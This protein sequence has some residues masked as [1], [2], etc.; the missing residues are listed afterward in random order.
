[1]TQS[2]ATL[3]VIAN[4]RAAEHGVDR[5]GYV[6]PLRSATAGPLR[7]W[8]GS[9]AARGRRIGVGLPPH[10]R[11]RRRPRVVAPATAPNC[12]RSFSSASGSTLRPQRRGSAGNAGAGAR[13]RGPGN[14]GSV[15][16]EHLQRPPIRHP[17]PPGLEIGICYGD[18]RFRLTVCQ[19]HR[20]LS[21]AGQ[22]PG[23]AGLPRDYIDIGAGAAETRPPLSDLL[24]FARLPH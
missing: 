4:P 11:V 19:E 21:A 8:A 22:Q 10:Q 14:I 17:G 12:A 18:N 7:R 23:R 1:M 6:S 16:F 3:G 24:E 2:Q 13:E 5:T 20:P 15:A 9:A